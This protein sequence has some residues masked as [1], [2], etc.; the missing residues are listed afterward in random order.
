MQRPQELY[1]IKQAYE[2]MKE[3]TQSPIPIIR[4]NAVSILAILKNLLAAIDPEGFWE[5]PLE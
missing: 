3:L 2:A 1:K 5:D 4:D